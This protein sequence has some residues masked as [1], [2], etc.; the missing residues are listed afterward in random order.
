[1]NCKVQGGVEFFR[2]NGCA[3]YIEGVKDISVMF[4]ESVSVVPGDTLLTLSTCTYERLGSYSLN[5]LV[6]VAKL[7]DVH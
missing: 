5:R 2:I 7:V 3:C 1:M 6:V 4:N